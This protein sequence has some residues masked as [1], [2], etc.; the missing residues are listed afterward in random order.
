MSERGRRTSTTQLAEINNDI[1][2]Q[3]EQIKN[4]QKTAAQ[5]ENTTNNIKEGLHRQRGVIQN[6]IDTNNEVKAELIKANKKTN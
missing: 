1:Y 4:M 5:T 3:N 6:N 2:R